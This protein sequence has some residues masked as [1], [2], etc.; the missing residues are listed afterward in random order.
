MTV[1]VVATYFTR[2]LVRS[3]FM[4]CKIDQ[5]SD[6]FTPRT[7]KNIKKL[8]SMQNPPKSQCFMQGR[9]LP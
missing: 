6:P 7:V 8:L 1:P 4:K 5:K 9:A 3:Y 2:N